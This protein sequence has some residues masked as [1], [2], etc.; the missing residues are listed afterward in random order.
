MLIDF[1]NIEECKIS[2]FHNGKKDVF[3]KA[4]NDNNKKIMLTRMISG[5]SN[6]LHKHEFNSEIIYVIS[7][8][9][10]AYTDGIKEILKPGVVSYCPIGSSHEIKNTGKEDLVCFNLID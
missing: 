7:G 10:E 4:F 1:K 6:G 5:S 9:G 3:Y 2:N 8:E